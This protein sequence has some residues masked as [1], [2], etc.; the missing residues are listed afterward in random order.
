MA[1][2]GFM[3]KQQICVNSTKRQNTTASIKQWK[4]SCVQLQVDKV[5]KLYPETYFPPVL[6]H[7]SLNNPFK[8]S[9]VL[10]AIIAWR[11]CDVKRSYGGARGDSVYGGF[12]IRVPGEHFRHTWLETLDAS[13]RFHQPIANGLLSLQGSTQLNTNGRFFRMMCWTALSET[14]TWENMVLLFS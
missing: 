10:F 14:P 3:S 11:C 7:F 5:L 1:F 4:N 2:I 12:S 8:F 9:Y 13:T 6:L